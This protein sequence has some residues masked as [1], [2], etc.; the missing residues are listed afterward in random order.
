MVVLYFREVYDIVLLLQQRK[1]E[2]RHR[3]S[4]HTSTALQFRQGFQHAR[5]P[6]LDHDEDPITSLVYKK[7]SQNVSAS[8]LNTAPGDQDRLE[9]PSLQFQQRSKHP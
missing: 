4:D 5:Q 9:R 8:R 7:L 3:N 6:L 1:C 2:F